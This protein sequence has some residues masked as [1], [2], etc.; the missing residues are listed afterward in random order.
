[1]THW[2]LK[3]KEVKR[4]RTTSA[5]S[6]QSWNSGAGSAVSADLRHFNPARY[7]LTTTSL[8]SPR[9]TL[10]STQKE[11]MHWGM[12]FNWQAEAAPPFSYLYIDVLHVPHEAQF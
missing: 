7:P 2:V 9:Q 11:S 12:V 1:M 4:V 3:E 5:R 8:P 10:P 6:C